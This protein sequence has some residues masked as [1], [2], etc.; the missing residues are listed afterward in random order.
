[1]C[2]NLTRCFIYVYIINIKQNSCDICSLQVFQDL[3]VRDSES[4]A[5]E[6]TARDK[7]GLF[8]GV[9][10]LGSVKYDA[11]KR[12]YDSRVSLFVE[13][14]TYNVCIFHFFFIYFLLFVPESR[15]DS[16]A[17]HLSE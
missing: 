13:S 8:A 17:Q 5:V 14:I 3:I 15:A 11:L 7:Q 10:F 6:L 12:V 2:C 9:L 16:F 1:M 4:V